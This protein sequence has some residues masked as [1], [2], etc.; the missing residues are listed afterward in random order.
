MVPIWVFRYETRFWNWSSSFATGCPVSKLCEWRNYIEPSSGTGSS[1]SSTGS[2]IL[3]RFQFGNVGIPVLELDDQFRNWNGAKM[4]SNIYIAHTRGDHPMSLCL[5]VRIYSSLCL[6][7]SR[8]GIQL[9]QD[10]ESASPE[11][12]DSGLS[13][14]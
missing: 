7:V 6:K 9:S 10:M 5:K 11:S 14:D 3:A 13:Q 12:W 8:N 2:P 4:G 1:S